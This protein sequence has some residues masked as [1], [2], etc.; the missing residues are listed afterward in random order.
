VGDRR[1]QRYKQLYPS[2]GGPDPT[3][4][5]GSI[6]TMGEMKS[7][8]SVMSQIL[9]SLVNVTKN[10]GLYLVRN[11]KLMKDFQQGNK[12]DYIW[13]KILEKFTKQ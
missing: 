1:A 12:H 5:D 2:G 6:E 9:L 13:T 10:P 11:R 3:L 8:R 7:K 4:E